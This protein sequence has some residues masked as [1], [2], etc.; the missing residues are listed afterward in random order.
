MVLE[1]FDGRSTLPDASINPVEGVTSL[2]SA[3]QQVL[4]NHGANTRF[5][6]LLPGR[7]HAHGLED[8]DAEGRVLAWRGG[9][10]GAG[11][12]RTN[13]RHVR[14]EIIESGIMS[15]DDFEPEL[16]RLDDPGLLIPSPIMWTAWGRR[17]A[18]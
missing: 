8:V 6:R 11:V 15:E 2:L 3:I 5:G 12:H 13:A 16:A 1:E 4:G 7:L 18:K 9:S 17:R 10:I 14:A